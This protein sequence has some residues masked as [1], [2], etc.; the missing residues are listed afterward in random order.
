MRTTEQQQGFGAPRT[1]AHP[2]SS[3]SPCSESG[4][5]AAR[6]N[7]RKG[8]VSV[9]N[10]ARYFGKTPRW[11]KTRAQRGEL[12]L[13]KWSSV[14]QTVSWASIFAFEDAHRVNG[15]PKKFRKCLAN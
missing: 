1:G 10:A 14:D 13:F 8:H 5:R 2:D 12:E 4:S 15:A 6:H 9:P 11:V 3:I 7:P